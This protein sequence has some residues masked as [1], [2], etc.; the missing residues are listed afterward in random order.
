M[1]QGTAPALAMNQ[2]GQFGI[3]GGQASDDGRRVVRERSTPRRPIG[4]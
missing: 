3:R 1:L 2:L 4:C